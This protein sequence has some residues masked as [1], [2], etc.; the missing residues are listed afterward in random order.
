[1][2]AMHLRMISSRRLK[3]GMPKFAFVS[4]DSLQLPSLVVVVFQ[5]SHPV[6]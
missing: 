5:Q 3:L 6:S 4:Q 1:M 2:G